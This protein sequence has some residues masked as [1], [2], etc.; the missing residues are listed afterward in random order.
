M[1]AQ[2]T[3]KFIDYLMDNWFCSDY[4]VAL[5]RLL[6]CSDNLSVLTLLLI[7]FLHL[8]TVE[9]SLGGRFEWPYNPLP[10]GTDT[11]RHLTT[12]EQS[13]VRQCSKSRRRQLRSLSSRRRAARHPRG[14]STQQLLPFSGQTWLRTIARS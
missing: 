11:V 5:P 8:V 9:V 12:L 10:V 1:Y 14:T 7:F 2:Q 13:Q 6:R 4:S 3:I